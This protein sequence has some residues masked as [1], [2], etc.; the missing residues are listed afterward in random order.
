LT[1]S[2]II[3]PDSITLAIVNRSSCGALAHSSQDTKGMIMEEHKKHREHEAKPDP[4]HAEKPDP[5]QEAEVADLT[6]KAAE[7]Q[8]KDISDPYDV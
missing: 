7:P 6:V 8:V 2:R 4:K 5:Q 3:R 1:L